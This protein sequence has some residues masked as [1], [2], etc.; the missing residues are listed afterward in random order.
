MTRVGDDVLS[1][2][3]LLIVWLLCQGWHLSWI[4]SLMSSLMVS[5]LSLYLVLVVCWSDFTIFFIKFMWYL[6]LF[7][8]FCFHHCYV[9]FDVAHYHSS[10]SPSNLSIILQ[11]FISLRESARNIFAHLEFFKTMPFS[12]RMAI[13]CSVQ[14]KDVWLWS[15]LN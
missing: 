1:S 11:M 9:Q 6:L 5:M 10:Q 8:N 13:R 12:L 14:T 15:I 2:I 3:C 7:T 4:I